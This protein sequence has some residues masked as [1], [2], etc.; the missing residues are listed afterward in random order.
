MQFYTDQ[1][2]EGRIESKD[3]GRETRKFFLNCIYLLL[4]R[5]DGKKFESIMSEYASQMTHILLLQVLKTS[6]AQFL[7]GDFSFPNE[8]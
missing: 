5:F 6:L 1:E 3:G 4:G 2:A 8:T 7:V